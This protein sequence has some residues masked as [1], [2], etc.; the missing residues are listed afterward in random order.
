MSTS[1]QQLQDPFTEPHWKMPGYTGY[2]RGVGETFAKTPVM[3]QLETRE[4]PPD[5]FLY[6]R[7]KAPPETSATDAAR[8][9]CSSADAHGPSTHHDVL[10]PRLQ[11][12]ARQERVKARASN[13]SL[14]DSR[15]HSHGTSYRSDFAAPLAAGATLRSPLQNKD[16]KAADLRHIYHS[17]FNRIGPERLESMLE[18]MRER[19]AG[20]MGNANNNAFKLR[21]LFKMWDSTGSGRIYIEDFRVMTESVGMQLDDDSLLALFSRHDLEATGTLDYSALM[22][23]LLDD[24]M[25]ALYSAGAPRSPHPDIIRIAP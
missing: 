8:D 22:R 1:K 2:I 23:N 19:L 14:G 24:D 13:I 25:Y 6:A 9:A 21:K 12:Q 16:L 15:L 17:A 18:A 7:S 10:W 11:Q 5:S 3:A 20:K 4:P